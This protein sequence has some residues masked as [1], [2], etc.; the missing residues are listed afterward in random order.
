MPALSPGNPWNL[1]ISYSFFGRGEVGTGEEN[2]NNPPKQGIKL[3]GLRALK[4]PGGYVIFGLL[5]VFNFGDWKIE[6]VG[7][8]WKRFRSWEVSVIQGAVCHH[9]FFQGKKHAGCLYKYPCHLT[10]LV[11]FISSFLG[12]THGRI[13]WG[14]GLSRGLLGF[15]FWGDFETGGSG[16]S[17]LIL[18]LQRGEFDHQI[19]LSW[20][21][22]QPDTES[23]TVFLSPITVCFPIKQLRITFFGVTTFSGILEEPQWVR[24]ELQETLIFGCL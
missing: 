7:F 9:K 14:W 6:S 2:L 19:L 10:R 17:V 21:D 5:L 3:L 8:L 12:E 23:V 18:G 1:H 20:K 15:Q 4:S 13:F 24:W 16:N 11:I 22:Q